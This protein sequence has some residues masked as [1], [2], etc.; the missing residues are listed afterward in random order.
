MAAGTV[1][2]TEQKHTSVRVTVIDWV[3]G[4]DGDAGTATGTFEV[5]GEILKVVT[6]PGA[7]APTDDYD[8]TLVDDDGHD[9]AEGTLGNRDTANTEV[10]YPF[11]E[12][13]LTD[14]ANAVIY[15]LAHSGTLT[16]TL[17]NA[18]AAKVG[19]CKVYW[20]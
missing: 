14:T 4:T 15:P 3:S 5:D 16:F 10:V 2:V 13:T 17:A 8:I 11:K 7:T 18:G 9:V 20:R 6:N 1:T 12:L 19:S